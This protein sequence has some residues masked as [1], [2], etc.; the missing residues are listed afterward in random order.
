MRLGRKP[1]GAETGNSPPPGGRVDVESLELGDFDCIEE[2]LRFAFRA[3]TA[4]HCRL[5]VR[6]PISNHVPP[7]LR[8]KARL[9]KVEAIVPGRP[10]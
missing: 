5:P 9:S 6:L 10:T 8:R 1:V 3:E 7:A 4:A 2:H